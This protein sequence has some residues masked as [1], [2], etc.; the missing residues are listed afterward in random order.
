MAE[1]KI[2]EFKMPA[3]IKFNENEWVKILFVQNGW[4]QVGRI[5]DGT[6]QVGCHL[7]VNQIELV[8]IGDRVEWDSF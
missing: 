2:A 5:Q 3:I 1:S 6:I 7:Q 4:I 8:W